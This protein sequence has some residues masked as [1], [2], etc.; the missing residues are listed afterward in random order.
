MTLLNV[1]RLSFIFTPLAFIE[2]H[3][4]RFETKGVGEIKSKG[5]LSISTEEKISQSLRSLTLK[6]RTGTKS[7]QI[8]IFRQTAGPIVLS[9]SSQSL[10]YLG[11]KIV[12]SDSSADDLSNYRKTLT[13]CLMECNVL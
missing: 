12:G 10:A 5:V 1:L 8:E 2:V 6:T 13:L 9:V 11:L 4:A 7:Y 3:A